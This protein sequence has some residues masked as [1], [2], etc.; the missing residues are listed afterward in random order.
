MRAAAMDVDGEEEEEE[1][2]DEV[3]NMRCPALRAIA[4]APDLLWFA[5]GFACPVIAA[6]L[7]L[8]LWRGRFAS[9]GSLAVRLVVCGHLHPRLHH[10]PWCTDSMVHSQEDFS[11]LLCTKSM[12]LSPAIVH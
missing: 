6:L 12:V 9:S 4:A 2:E 1:D 11:Y 3:R 10:L 8:C 7:P 5:S